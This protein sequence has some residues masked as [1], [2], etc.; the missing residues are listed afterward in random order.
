MAADPLT[1]ALSF[2]QDATRDSLRVLVI[3]AHPIVGQSLVKLVSIMPGLT[4]C[5]LAAGGRDGLACAELTEPDVALVDADLP[6]DAALPTIRALRACLPRTRVIAL[7]L[8]PGRRASMLAAGAHAFLLKDA[9]YQALRSAIVAGR[10]N[11]G[12]PVTA[13]APAPSRSHTRASC[14]PESE[15]ESASAWTPG[16]SLR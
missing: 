5:G 16:S 7:G 13:P 4:V 10:P 9:G 11:V 1:P 14:G 6:D 15:S 12:R 2:A 3:D 8:Y